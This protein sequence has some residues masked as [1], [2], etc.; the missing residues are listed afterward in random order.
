MSAHQHVARPGEGRCFVCGRNM[1]PPDAPGRPE[2]EP[3]DRRYGDE[4]VTECL[5][6]PGVEW[7]CPAMKAITRNAARARR[8]RAAAR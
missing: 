4:T 6:C 7:P 1:V 3:V 5:V 8:Q 2:H